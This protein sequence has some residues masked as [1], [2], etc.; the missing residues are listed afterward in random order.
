MCKA[1]VETPHTK[2]HIMQ[3]D[4]TSWLW[5]LIN[6]DKEPKKSSVVRGLWLEKTNKSTKEKK[7]KLGD[8]HMKKGNSQTSGFT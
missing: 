3:H 5:T 4:W 2:C 8:I 6:K 1:F 7:G